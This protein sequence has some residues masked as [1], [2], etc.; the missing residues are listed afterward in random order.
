MRKITFLLLHLGFGGIET[1]TINTCNN[2]CDN[3]DIEIIS[4][5]KLKGDQKD[6]LDSRINVKY[7]YNG[8]PNRE[9]FK[10][11]IKHFNI[12]NIF[13]EMFKAM[14]ILYLRKHLM[15]KEIKKSNSD[16]IVS[17]R[18]DYSLLLNKYGNSIKI[19]QE[20]CHH[21]G[22][23]KYISKLKKLKNINYMFALTDTLKNDYE[24]F[25][26]GSNVK[27]LVVPNMITMPDVVSNLDNNNL[28]TICRLHSVKKI[29]EMIDIFSKLENKDTKLYIVG[30]GDEEAKL[31]DI[32][33][34]KNL[35]DRII[36]TGYLSQEDM[37]P[38]LLDSSIFLMTS[39]TEGLPM[40]LLEA[41]SYGIPCI[42]YQTSSG[43]SDIID[44]DINGYIIENRDEDLYINTLNNLIKDR[45]K[46]KLFSINALEKAKKFSK[47]EVKKIW[48]DI[49]K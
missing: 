6:K 46:L 1:A 41:M 32:V 21:N 37:R 44:N 23:K 47:D 3:Y 34:S 24:K 27:V 25:L 35:D 4:F 33:H 22:N 31:K 29:D 38:Y 5:Y 14:H 8:G 7:L 15:I 11:A 42:A 13:K 9:E 45:E 28:I 39:L 2:L 40:V 16:F 17:T 18:L 43:V 36:F 12:I 49:L 48:I 30:T 26:S 20:H 19:V 10:S